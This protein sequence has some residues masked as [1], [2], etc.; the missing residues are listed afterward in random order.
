MTCD[1]PD[2]NTHWP[3]TLHFGGVKDIPARPDLGA[4]KISVLLRP[5]LIWRKVAEILGLCHEQLVNDAEVYNNMIRTNHNPTIH[6]DGNS[7]DQII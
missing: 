1:S 3:Y 2:Q 4:V 5:S 7:T 6:R